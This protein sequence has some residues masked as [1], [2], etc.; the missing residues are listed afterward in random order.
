VL[1]LAFL[2]RAG[3]SAANA[4]GLVMAFV[5][6]GLLFVFALFFQ[7]VQG[8]SAIAAGLRFLPLTVA[9]ILTGP[10]IGRLID[11]I[12]YRA[13]LATGA[14]LQGLGALLLLR[15]HATS[16]YGPVWWPFAIIGI[17]YGL[18]ST[19]MAAAVLGAVPRER[20]GMAS[21]TNLTAR[22]AGG[23]FGVAI[24]G[25]ALPAAHPGGHA[26][27]GQFTA[28]LHTALIV[29]AAVACV[30]AVLAAALISGDPQVRSQAGRDHGTNRAAQPDYADQAQ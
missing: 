8:Q 26:F 7:E 18:M 6:V 27:A 4:S 17:G 14:A 11:R 13:P 3:Y 23:V 30:D 1:P 28:G 21:S 9:F 22:L 12:G 5:T 25:A 15:V 24:L 10:L 16:G 2:R 29:A 20:A 19:P